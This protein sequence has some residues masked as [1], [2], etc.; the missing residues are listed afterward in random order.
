MDT[1]IGLPDVDN[2]LECLGDDKPGEECG[3]FGIYAPE[4]EVA[5][6]I[7]LALIALQHRGQVD[8]TALGSI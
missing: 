3:L 8:T 4:M 5:Q 1:D 2:E 6:T 7:C